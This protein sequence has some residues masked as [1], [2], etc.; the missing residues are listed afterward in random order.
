MS[1]TLTAFKELLQRYQLVWQQA[2][3]RRHEM[4]APNRLP[5]E[6]QF[7]PAALALQESPVSPK[8]R[9]A[10]WLLMSFA[11]IAL[12][13]ACFGKID[14][15]A[16]AQGKIVPSDRIKTIQPLETATVSA[17]YV[18]EGQHVEAG[19]ALIDFDATDASADIEHLQSALNDGRLQ[20]IRAQTMLLSLDTDNR[21]KHEPM[22]PKFD[23]I[24]TLRQTQEQAL[25]HSEWQEFSTKQAQL[26]ASLKTK[27]AEQRSYGETV[28]KLQRSLV[29]TRARATDY[30]KLDKQSYIP[31]HDYLDAQQKLIDQEGEL[32][33]QQQQLQQLT[34][35]IEEVKRQQQA[36]TAETLRN[37]QDK[38]REGKQQ[39]VQYQQEL[40]KA[41]QHGKLRRLTA[42][43]AG[44]VQQL[45]THTVGGV[46]TPAQALMIIVPQDNPLEIEAYIENKDIGFVYAGQEAE[47]KIETFPYTKYGTIHA[48]V[49]DVSNDA[50]NDEKKGLIYT[51]HVK[52]DRTTIPVENKTVN[53]TPGMTVTV[54]IKTGKRR[55]MEYFLSPLMEY[56]SESFK[57]R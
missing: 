43:V 7:L 40:I 56:Q 14:I 18:K 15:V 33:N 57:E 26:D 54:E 34:S 45:A 24:P 1:N 12:L 50:V 41:Q 4:E 11:L 3:A 36:L 17:I 25:L 8:P 30:A 22:L 21:S 6:L 39:T 16:S 2:W 47:A 52:L 35:E 10:M 32:A 31:R 28:H 46:V 37:L 44:T 29:I 38:L 53:L 48:E 13:W 51:A 23:D 20:T 42:P 49:T 19:D 27:Q 9:L 55:V 5:H